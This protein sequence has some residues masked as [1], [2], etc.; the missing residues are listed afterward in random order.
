MG[1]FVTETKVIGNC[2][3]PPGSETSSGVSPCNGFRNSPDEGELDDYLGFTISQCI[4]FFWAGKPL[5]PHSL[6]AL[7]WTS[8]GSFKIVEM[9]DGESPIRILWDRDYV[10]PKIYPHGPLEESSCPIELPFRTESSDLVEDLE[11]AGCIVRVQA[12]QGTYGEHSSVGSLVKPEASGQTS[13]AFGGHVKVRFQKERLLFC[14]EPIS[15]VDPTLTDAISELAMEFDSTGRLKRVFWGGEEECDT[16]P[17]VW[18]RDEDSDVPGVI[19]PIMAFRE[20]DIQI[21]SPGDFNLWLVYFD[22][23]GK[24]MHRCLYAKLCG[25]VISNTRVSGSSQQPVCFCLDLCIATG[26]CPGPIE[27]PRCPSTASVDCLTSLYP[28]CRDDVDEPGFCLY[29]WTGGCCN[30]WEV[31]GQSDVWIVSGDD[32]SVIGCHYVAPFYDCHIRPH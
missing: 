1:H 24:Y 9:D 32:L 14:S 27:G 17:I 18:D 28:P 25:C 19:V 30:P 21:G 15:S 31:S 23:C 16:N 22:S 26:F 2:P 13:S 12:L 10:F 29:E 6:H 5:R 20:G 7:R 11:T 3:P 8:D 4:Q